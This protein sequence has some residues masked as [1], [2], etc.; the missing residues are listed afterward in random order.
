M[1]LGTEGVKN[2]STFEMR[3]TCVRLRLLGQGLLF[4]LGWVKLGQVKLDYRL[5]HVGL[6][7]M[8]EIPEVKVKVK[9]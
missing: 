2:D 9:V 4:R 6:G 3:F 8:S 5:G 7:Q 1:R